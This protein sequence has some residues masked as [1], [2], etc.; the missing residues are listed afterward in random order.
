MN[1]NGTAWRASD[2]LQRTVVFFMLQFV[3]PLAFL[4]LLPLLLVPRLP[5][6]RIRT[7]L[8]LSVP[9]QVRGQA[10]VAAPPRWITNLPSYCLFGFLCLLIVLMA[11]PTLETKETYDV[12]KSRSLLILL[13]T[14]ASMVQTGLLQ[15]VVTGFLAPFIQDRPQEDR[16]A[17]VRF[18]TDASGGIFTRNHQGVILELTRPS[19]I[20]QLNLDRD[21]ALLRARGT[22]MGVGLFKALT[23][24][25]EDEVDTRVA[26]KRLDLAAQKTVYGELQDVLR[27]FLWHLL[28]KHEGAFPLH[29]P[30]VP[31][32]AEVGAGKSLVVIT[33][34]Q[35]LESTSRATQV[36]YLQLLGYY[37]ELGV[38]HL[39]FINL[40]THPRQLNP[41]LQKYPT[42]KA[43]T[44]NQTQAGLQSIFTE[45]AEDM[46][47]MEPDQGIVSVRTQAH[48]IFHWF[49]PGL[50][51]LWLAV[52]LRLHKRMRRFP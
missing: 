14:S 29:I 34:G 7:Y 2:P 51:L 26:E 31:R 15:R 12:Q 13:D 35:L 17:V 8:A 39:Y 36:D 30:L 4:L 48:L 9:P 24:F 28:Q 47:T 45:I 41:F 42:W 10:R 16:I 25:V 3:Y 32:L 37:A 46:E 1:G 22:Q 19:L 49:L 18:D 38:H 27:R 44:W 6:R 11:E 43:Y 33:D 52:G 40:K 20:H 23:S 50:I 5:Q 21:K